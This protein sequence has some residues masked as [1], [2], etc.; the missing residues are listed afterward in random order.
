MTSKSLLLTLSSCVCCRDFLKTTIHFSAP[1][2]IPPQSQNLVMFCHWKM[3][4]P[5]RV[6]W[7]IG[8]GQTV[9]ESWN[10]SLCNV[11]NPRRKSQQQRA[12][13]ECWVASCV[14]SSLLHGC[15]LCLEDSV[16]HSIFF[17]TPFLFQPIIVSTSAHF[18]RQIWK[19]SQCYHLWVM[20][21]RPGHLCLSSRG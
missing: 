12:N 8:E 3:C 17:C 11:T 6:C 16:L 19:H 4:V 9:A 15:S 2:F 7:C 18:A 1:W 20:C 21:N 10:I 13:S 5:L 14:G